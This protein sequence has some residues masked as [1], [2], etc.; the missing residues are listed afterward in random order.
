VRLRSRRGRL[1]S[2]PI[3]VWPALLVTVVVTGCGPRQSASDRRAT[4]PPVQVTSA[5][6]VQEPVIRYLRLTGSLTAD[7]QADVAAETVGR[8]VSTP[9]ER[10]SHVNAGS[11]LVTL[12]PV[13]AQAQAQ[14]SDANVAQIEARLA[15][16]PGQPFD[17][18]RVPEVAASR[19]SKELAEADFAR[20]QTLLDQKVVSQAEYDQRRTQVEAT[21]NQYAAARNQSQQ[22]F[23]SY[24]AA[25]ARASLARKALADTEVRAPFAGLVVDRKVSTGD[26]VTRGTKIATIVNVSPLRVELTVPEQ[27]IGMVRAGQAIRIQVDAYPDRVFAGQVRFV[28][29][30]LRADQRSLTVEAVMPND[31]GLL[32]PGMFVSAEIQLAVSEPALLVPT[33]AILPV[34]GGGRVFVLR[35][36]RAEERLVTPG[37][38]FG[39]RT[40]IVKGV[41]AGELVAVG[42][43]AEL[44]D[45]AQVVVTSSPAA[46]STAAP[47]APS[48][49][50]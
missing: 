13:E 7:E 50:K 49:R 1:S 27:S 30:A 46:T 48:T 8:V 29:P 47:P 10:G 19:A 21:R 38:E 2:A 43:V 3:V 15:L 41:A 28:A 12:S 45:G 4:A 20:I 16:L 5:V 24:E 26:F 33:T 32:M 6:V 18:E 11:V 9:V 36:G 37:L 17:V 25:R 31:G 23:R 35:G 40:E 42:R 44:V 39:S 14:E 22:Q 34:T